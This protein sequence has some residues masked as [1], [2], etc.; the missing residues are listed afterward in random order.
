MKKF[1]IGIMITVLP[2]SIF[3]IGGLGLSVNTSTFTV[4]GVLPSW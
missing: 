3:A 1:L 4:D 2:T